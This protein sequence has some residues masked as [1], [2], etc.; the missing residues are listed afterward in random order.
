M[1][2]LLSILLAMMMVIGLF[3]ATAFAAEKGVAINE[4]NFPDENFRECVTEFDT[5]NDGYLNDEELKDA[6]YI[7]C[8]EKGIEDLTGIEYFSYLENLNCYDN[9]LISLD[10]SK[11]TALIKLDCS[12]NELE[13]LVVSN[14]T[15]LTELDCGENWLTSLDV[16]GC[17]A[18]ETLFCYYNELESLDISNNT[19]LT[20]LGCWGNNLSSL[21]VSNNPNLESLDCKYNELT[22]LDISNVP[23]ILDAVKEGIKEEKDD[24]YEYYKDDAALIVDKTTEIITSANYVPAPTISAVTNCST[25][26]KVTWDAVPEAEGYVVYRSVDGGKYSKIATVDDGSV[27]YSDKDAKKNLTKYSY[28][29]VA[30]KT[31]DGVLYESKKSA[32][33]ETCFITRVSAPTLS[34]TATGVK[35]TWKAIDGVDGYYVYR[36]TKDGAYE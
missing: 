4:K 15:A 8:A 34:N 10:V 19:E 29:V 1:K 27:S 11:C 12:D 20:L 7:T 23:L 18:L 30:Y 22:I 6:E 14:C 2:K 26:V 13:S 28:Q 25:Y 17:T 36:S 35:V 9:Y 24:T 16:K 21:D 5:D 31:V 3:P 32:A 33:K